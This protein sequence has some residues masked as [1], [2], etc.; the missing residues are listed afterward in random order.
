[1]RGLGG[2]VEGVLELRDERVRE[3]RVSQ[4]REGE[5]EDQGQRY[6]VEGLWTTFG[7]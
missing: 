6:Q 3:Q 7:D 4:D 1:V 5:G 2:V